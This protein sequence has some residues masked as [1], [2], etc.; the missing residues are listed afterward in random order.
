[1][2]EEKIYAYKVFDKLG[3]V[4]YRGEIS[5]YGKELVEEIFKTH[6]PDIKRINDIT[7]MVAD[8]K[9]W[10]YRVDIDS[11]LYSVLIF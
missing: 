4:L 7:E 10:S 6:F 5:N 9:I 3:N 8:E 1:M 11:D 2:G